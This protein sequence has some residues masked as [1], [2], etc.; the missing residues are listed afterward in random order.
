MA[1]KGSKF[2]ADFRKSHQG[3]VRH[4]DFTREFATG[5]HDKLADEV[6]GERVS[7]GNERRSGRQQR[8]LVDRTRH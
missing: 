5:D 7:G 4:G 6:H 1:K 8:W 2:R 3:R